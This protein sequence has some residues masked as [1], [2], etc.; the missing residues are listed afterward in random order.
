MTVS[1]DMTGFVTNPWRS[2]RRVNALFGEGLETMSPPGSALLIGSGHRTPRTFA[3]SSPTTRCHPWGGA[4]GGSAGERQI[5]WVV[6]IT[7][8]YEA[9]LRWGGRVGPRAWDVDFAMRVLNRQSGNVIA[10]SSFLES[11]YTRRGVRTIRVPTLIDIDHGLWPT[12]DRPPGRNRRLRFVYAGQ[13]G[14]KDAL[15]SLLAGFNLARKRGLPVCLHLCGMPLEDVLRSGVRVEKIIRELGSTLTIH[16]RF[17][18]PSDAIDLMRSSD[19]ALLVKKPGR[20]VEAQFPT[21]LTQYMAAGLPVL[22][23]RTGD[24]GDYVRDGREGFLTRSHRPPDIADTLGRICASREALPAMGLRSR[25]R[26]EEC[27][28][29]RRYSDHLGDFFLEL[30]QAR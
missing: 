14:R 19:V 20:L 24:V 16:G 3:L 10:I 18:R 21:K 17:P 8:W 4:F 28:D 27:F 9:P 2:T 11:Y 29:Y 5:P 15:D 25:Q 13:A 7:E 1:S 12:R 26:A 22:A 6:D 30:Q 23:N